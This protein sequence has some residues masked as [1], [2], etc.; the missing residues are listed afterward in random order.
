MKNLSFVLI[1]CCFSNIF[2]QSAVTFLPPDYLGRVPI[3]NG[4][5]VEVLKFKTDQIVYA[6]TNGSGLHISYD[7]GTTWAK[8]T[9]FPE[10]SPYIRDF[11]L[12]GN[13]D[14]YVATFGGGIICSNDNGLTW[15]QKNNGLLNLHVQAITI[16]KTGKLICGTY[17]GGIYF[18]D[19]KAENWQRTDKGLRYDNITCLTTMYNGFILA[20]TY[21]GGFYVSRDT[22]KTWVVSNTQLTN[23]F[24]N[25]LVKD[26]SGKVYAATNGDGVLLTGDGITW[27][28][29]SNKFHYKESGEI[30]NLV[31]TNLAAVGANKYQMVMGTRSAG[32][33]FWDDIWNCWQNS[34]DFAVGVT[35]MDVSPNGT[36]L[37]ATSLNQATR[38]TDNGLK[39]TI[40]ATK[41]VN[42]NTEIKDDLDDYLVISPSKFDNTLISFSKSGITRKVYKSLNQGNDWTYLGKFDCN[43]IND[44]EISSK[45]DI[46]VA[47]NEGIFASLDSGKTFTLVCPSTGD[48]TY[49]NFVDIEY[50][51][52]ANKWGAIWAYLDYSDP[53]LPI[54]NFRIYQSSDNGSSWT[55]ASKPEV[56]SLF[57]DKNGIWFLNIDKSFV[58]STDH[59]KTFTVIS[60]VKSLKLFYGMNG[61]IYYF[62]NK[63]N[64]IY[65]SK[66]QGVTY[67]NMPFTPL[68]SFAENHWLIKKLVG[69]IYGNCYIDIRNSTLLQGI[70]YEV[71]TTGDYGENWKTIRGC[72]N[73]YPI[74]DVKCNYSGYT[75]LLTNALYKVVDSLQLRPPKV[76]SPQDGKMGEEINPLFNWKSSPLAEEY[77]FQLDFSDQFYGPFEV[78]VSADTTCK[79]ILNLGYAQEY[80]WRVRSKTHSAHSDWY[81]GSFT[82]GLEPPKLISP[83][84]GK[85]GVPLSAGLLWHTIAEATHYQI[86]VAEDPNFDKIVFENENHTDTT[87]I[88]DKLTG[89]KTYYWRVK[90]Y[91]A[92]NVSSWSEVWDFRT[93]MGPPKLIYP[94][95]ES[96]DKQ[97]SEQ[98]KWRK[99]D[100]A[101]TYFIQVAKDTA[102]TDLFFEGS[103]GADTFKIIDNMLPE[104][105]YFWHVASINT[106]GTS[107]Y[108]ETWTF[109]TA[110]KSVELTY[111]ENAK[112]NISP[113]IK[114]TWAEHIGGNQFQIQISKTA[115]FKTTVVDDKVNNILEYQ[116]NKLEYYKDY[117]WRV[118]LI[119]GQRFGLWSDVWSFKTGLQSAN[120]LNPPDKSFDQPNALKFKWYDVVG[121]KFYQ[122]QISKNETFTDLVYSTDSLTKAEQYVEDLEP[123]ILY[124][125]RVRAWNDESYG[126]SQWSQ[127]WTF[128]TGQVTLVLRNPK[129]G[130]SGVPIPTLLT[131][132]K[133][134][135]AE[136]YYLQIARSAD[137]GNIIFDKDSIYENQYLLSKTDVE[138]STN[139]FW[140]VKGISKTYTTPWSETWQFTTGEV[141]VKESELFSSIKLYPNPTGNKAELIINYAETCD[142]KI[143][144]S[145]TEGKIIRTDVIQLLNGETRYEI[146][147]EKLT[148]G[149]Y[150][151]TIIKPSGFITRELVV[152]K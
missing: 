9:S 75:Y 151:I 142:G 81:V 65:V 18:S 38:S 59:G 149:T 88:T 76:I 121:V 126:T 84:K 106:D 68:G 2:L 45:G 73:M 47:A 87:I 130:S 150:Y 3:P 8:S 138:V 51:A 24:V 11:I 94:A 13:N 122:L 70:I 46:F 21:G 26:E 116:T 67:T 90:A 152:V 101:Q 22:C 91:T 35:A 74:R 118:R 98:F 105:D 60:T 146:D 114:F 136:Y 1:L 95:N 108:S 93:V 53:Q 139:Y 33:Y 25:D 96:I 55:N 92:K 113:D 42:V 72:Y 104:T 6:G 145:T 115:D 7:G 140:R 83:E 131:W 110:L 29:F 109:R 63:D 143:L 117:F 89:L 66:D 50:D 23:L 57:I 80:Y 49:S 78:N 119:V 69:D 71:Y 132:F 144:I 79:V 86:Q 39:W 125:W 32:L 14:I 148:S 20:G 15:S 62:V 16:T 134:S 123:E 127:V 124:Y 44:V 112:V 107:D 85:V 129:S 103:A 56:N 97:L 17:G 58:K 40:C 34:G 137:F 41:I 141:S 31:D 43:R 54:I 120:L 64:K 61:D 82:V 10:E 48:L 128:T 36:I 133:A 52:K 100:E 5:E 12:V 111:P 30:K 28:T 77:E 4:S 37:A 27:N 147:T 99:S 102:F 135:S 19:D